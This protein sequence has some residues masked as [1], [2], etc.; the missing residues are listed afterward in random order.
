M[1]RSHSLSPVVRPS[2]RPSGVALAIATAAS[3]QCAAQT[4]PQAVQPSGAPVNSRQAPEQAKQ[5]ATPRSL[6]ATVTRSSGETRL[7]RPSAML[8]PLKTGEPIRSG[9]RVMTGAGGMVELR[10]VDGAVITLRPQTELVIDDYRFEA[11]SERSFFSLVRGAV[12]AISGSIGKRNRDDFR[13]QTPTAIVGIRGTEFE[14]V[15]TRCAPSGCA[16]GEPEGLTVSVMSGRVAV[17]NDAGTVEVPQGAKVTVR[18]RRSPAV[19][20]DASRAAPAASATPATSGAQRLE[21][22]AAAPGGGIAPESF[23][24][25]QDRP[26]R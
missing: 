16:S 26:S 19:F 5:A 3:L 7:L 25:L 20:A 4:V 21:S 15:E 11:D 18:D 24:S 1:S 8:T 23:G 2:S 12:H 17:T 6:A 14:L 10:F 13:L 22:K 9:D